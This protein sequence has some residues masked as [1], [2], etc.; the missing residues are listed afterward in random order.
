M[1]YFQEEL[2]FLAMMDRPAKRTAPF[3]ELAGK[4]WKTTRAKKLVKASP[5]SMLP[6]LVLEPRAINWVCAQ[7]HLS[8]ETKK[9][10]ET[11]KRRQR[12]LRPVLRVKDLEQDRCIDLDVQ[13]EAKSWCVNLDFPSSTVEAELGFMDASGRYYMALRSNSVRITQDVSPH[14]V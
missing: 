13:L 6:E 8:G 10:I 12:L 1:K 5:D 14:A 7:W 2:P 4:I 11:I 9:R 3:P